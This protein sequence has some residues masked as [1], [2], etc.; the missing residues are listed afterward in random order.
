[1]PK[2]EWTGVTT[3]VL[4]P[5]RGLDP[6]VSMQTQDLWI[7]EGHTWIRAHVTPRHTLF[8]PYGARSGPAHPEQLKEVRRTTCYLPSGER[9]RFEE[10]W[11][12]VGHRPLGVQWT[13][14]FRVR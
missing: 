14:A 1:M 11:K 6:E 9:V 4:E 5:E 12:V 8:T 7:K 13:G 2:E 3:F 10:H